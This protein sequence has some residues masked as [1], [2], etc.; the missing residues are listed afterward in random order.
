MSGKP[1]FVADSSHW[2]YQQGRREGFAGDKARRGLMSFF[3]AF[4]GDADTVVNTRQ[5]IAGFDSVTE[6]DRAAKAVP[7]PS[8]WDSDG[9]MVDRHAG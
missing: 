7:A 9:M 4:A 6:E 3:I 1:T 8:G 5:W 2:A